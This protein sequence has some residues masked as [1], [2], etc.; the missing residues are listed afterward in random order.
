[1]IGRCFRSWGFLS[2]WQWVSTQAPAELGL[3]SSA[4]DADKPYMLSAAVLSRA[5]VDA[6]WSAIPLGRH[7]GSGPRPLPSARVCSLDFALGSSWDY[8]RWVC[9][10]FQVKFVHITPPTGTTLPSYCKGRRPTSICEACPIWQ[11]MIS[12]GS[13]RLMRCLMAFK[14]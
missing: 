7:R 13:T 9:N 4:P 2:S 8:A 14:I 5:F 11:Q 1:M 6:G 10:N 12:F 3:P